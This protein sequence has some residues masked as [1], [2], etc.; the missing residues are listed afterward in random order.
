MKEWITTVTAERPPR[1]SPGTRSIGDQQEPDE[2][3]HVQV[4][5]CWTSIT[6]LE[7]KYI[8][9]VSISLGYPALTCGGIHQPS[10]FQLRAT[11]LTL[12]TGNV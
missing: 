4:A 3:F 8:S 10:S 9:L 7:L 2:C 5:S 11:T 12:L 1:V 6:T